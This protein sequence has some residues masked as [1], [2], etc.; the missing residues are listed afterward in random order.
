MHPPIEHT[1]GTDLRG[2][3]RGRENLPVYV[4]VSGVSNL[5]PQNTKFHYSPPRI[6]RFTIAESNGVPTAGRTLDTS[7][8]YSVQCLDGNLY[9]SKTQKDF[10]LRYFGG[11]FAAESILSNS[12]T[13]HIADSLIWDNVGDWA[14]RAKIVLHGSNFGRN[15]SIVQKV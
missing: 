2:T 1:Y 6:N 9:V 14:K 4:I 3:R 10:L 7:T 8:D 15:A 13:K 11:G 12:I 5:N